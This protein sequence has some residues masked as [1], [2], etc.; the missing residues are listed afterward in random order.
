M[1]TAV[2][3]AVFALATVVVVVVAPRMARVSDELTSRTRLGA[4]LFGAVFLGASTSL[5]GIVVTVSAA[6]AGQLGLAAAN[7]LGGIAAQ[8]MFLALA[9]VSYRKGAVQ[10]EAVSQKST[11]QLGLVVAL[12]ALVVIALGSPAATLGVH[13][14]TPLLILGYVGGIFIIRRIPGE[15]DHQKVD[16]ASTTDAPTQV[17]ESAEPDAGGGASLRGLWTRYGI[18]LVALGGS[19]VALSRSVEPI[20]SAIGLPL[21]AAGGLLTALATSSPELM[22]AIAAARR[23][24]LRLAVGDIA[25]GNAFDV[26]FVAAADAAVL[27]GLYAAL[28]STHVLLAGVALLFN[29]VLLMG[30]IRRGRA[31]GGRVAPESVVVL[32]GY[33]IVC[34]ALVLS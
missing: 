9:D 27:G 3:V 22:T 19:G 1:S 13:V 2:A 11:A 30:F 29:A 20:A 4:A 7:A 31:I 26:L 8:T 28:G 16:E 33:V 18:F 25:G 17:A 14:T 24:A 21:V 15:E 6:L 34:A 5:P 12:L 10:R 32:T 23:G